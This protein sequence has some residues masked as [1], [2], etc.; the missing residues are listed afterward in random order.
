VLTQLRGT[1]THPRTPSSAITRSGDGWRGDGCR[2]PP[3]PG[4]EQ[5]I[6][7]PLLIPLGLTSPSLGRT[8]GHSPPLLSADSC[9]LPQEGGLTL[10]SRRSCTP[11]EAAQLGCR[12]RVQRSQPWVTAGRQG[13]AAT[14]FVSPGDGCTV[15]DGSAPRSPPA[16]GRSRQQQAAAHPCSGQAPAPRATSGTQDG[17]RWGTSQLSC[18]CCYRRGSGSATA[19]PLFP[20]EPH[21]SFPF[22]P[23]HKPSLDQPV[24]PR[25]AHGA[26]ASH[27]ELDVAPGGSDIWKSWDTLTGR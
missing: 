27:A 6:S 5:P 17:S 18:P 12:A 9:D 15:G 2:L 16:A 21:G 11:R 10:S 14:H 24:M 25:P 26:G 19:A 3:S 4:P 7:A 22:H 1:P 23:S 13:Q 20:T 8:G